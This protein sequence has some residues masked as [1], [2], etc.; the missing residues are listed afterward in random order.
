M[1]SNIR[2][3]FNTAWAVAVR[4]ALRDQLVLQPRVAAA[5]FSL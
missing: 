5:R 2:H 4:A 1:F 3:W